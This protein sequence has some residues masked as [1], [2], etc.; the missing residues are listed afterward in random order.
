MSYFKFNEVQHTLLIKPI[1]LREEVFAKI[2]SVE[3]SATFSTSPFYLWKRTKRWTSR[4]LF[5]VQESHLNVFILT[6]GDIYC[7]S[8]V[9][10]E[11]STKIWAF[12]CNMTI[13]FILVPFEWGMSLK[14][15]EWIEL[16]SEL[17][18]N[19]SRAQVKI[20]KKLNR[21]HGK[22]EFWRKIFHVSLVVC[23][24]ENPHGTVSS[25][26]TFWLGSHFD[27]D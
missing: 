12:V 4:E 11:K 10:L 15:N 17:G 14:R 7:N 27:H 22:D 25:W 8:Y 19:R 20:F 21:R 9:W 5:I 24:R 2:G 6:F 26:I 23:T 3:F 18:S 1:G 16:L 13:L